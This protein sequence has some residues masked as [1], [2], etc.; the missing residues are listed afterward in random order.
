MMLGDREAAVCPEEGSGGSCVCVLVL[1]S[2][3]QTRSSTPKFKKKDTELSGCFLVPDGGIGVP[4]R[5]CKD[6]TKDGSDMRGS[7]REASKKYKAVANAEKPKALEL[8]YAAQMIV[9]VAM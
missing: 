3:L 9:L 8:G 2:L 6:S 5:R 1:S 4:W 7:L